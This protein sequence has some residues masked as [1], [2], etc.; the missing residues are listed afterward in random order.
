MDVIRSDMARVDTPNTRTQPIAH[1]MPNMFADKERFFSP[2]VK[3]A[4]ESTTRPENKGIKNVGG[5]LASDIDLAA[6]VDK[7]H[8]LYYLKLPEEEK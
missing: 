1:T 4:M 8:Q 2:A 6:Y 5:V 3:K 7:M